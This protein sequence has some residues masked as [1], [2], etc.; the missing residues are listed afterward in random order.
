MNKIFAHVA[1][2]QPFSGLS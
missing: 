2:L 1:F